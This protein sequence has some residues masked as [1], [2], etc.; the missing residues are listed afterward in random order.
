MKKNKRPQWQQLDF[1][2]YAEYRKFVKD[3]RI[4]HILH[5]RQKAVDLKRHQEA[6]DR[7]KYHEMR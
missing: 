3:V 4:A 7:R 2:S 5:E 6:A 1:R